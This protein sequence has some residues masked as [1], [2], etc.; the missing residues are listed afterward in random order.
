MHSSPPNCVK[1]RSILHADNKRFAVAETLQC[2]PPV[3]TPQAKV[4]ILGSMPGVRSLEAGQYYAHPRNLF[5]QIIEQLLDIP[6]A[7]P[8]SQR[9]QLLM[10]QNVALWDV[11]GRC[12]RAGS[13]DSAIRNATLQPND[14]AR[15]FAAHRHLTHVFFNGAKAEEVFQRRVLPGVSDLLNEVA[16]QRLPSTSPA[17]ASLS[18][19]EK[20]RAWRVVAAAVSRYG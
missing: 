6:A 15:F 12:E 11:I 19:D 1:I 8:Y 5:W 4:L 9:C 17:Y 16:F 20:C 10:A 14:F 7:A 3:E 13:L 2:F 18:F